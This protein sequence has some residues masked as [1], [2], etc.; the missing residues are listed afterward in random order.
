MVYKT[1]ACWIYKVKIKVAPHGFS[2][3]IFYSASSNRGPRLSFA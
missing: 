3:A 2:F 1:I